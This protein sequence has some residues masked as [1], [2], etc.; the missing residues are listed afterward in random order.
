MLTIAIAA[1]NLLVGGRFKWQLGD[2]RATTGASPVTLMHLAL[3]ATRS[4]LLSALRCHFLMA[5]PAIDRA[6]WA[7]LKRQFG[8]FGAAAGASP[9][10]LKHLAL[11][12]VLRPLAKLSL[13]GHA[14]IN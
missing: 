11:E 13:K 2:L 3:E 6:I 14:L 10:A 5:L 7:G 4:A 8:D 12:T 9:V 1:I